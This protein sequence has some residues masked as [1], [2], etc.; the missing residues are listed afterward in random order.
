MRSPTPDSIRRCAMLLR[1]LLSRRALRS[2]VLGP[3]TLLLWLPASGGLQ[4]APK[5]S[6]PERSALAPRNTAPGVRYVGS[7]VCGSCHTEIFSNFRQTGMGRSMLPADDSSVAGLPAPVTVFDQD[8]SQYF[9]ILRKDGHWY[10]SQYALDG[11]GK[12][13]FRQTYKMDYVIGAGDNG[14]GFLIKRGSYLFEAPLSYYSQSHSWSFSPGYQFRNQAFTRPVVA[15]CIGCHSGRPNPVEGQIARYKDPPFDELAVGCE[16]CHGPGDLHVKERTQEQMM[17]AA[18]TDS[19]DP[20]IVNPARLSGWFSDNICMR[21]HQGQDVRVDQPGT[22]ER[23]FR[24]GM[25]LDRVI[26]IF[27]VPLGTQPPSG[28]ML[29]EHYFGMTLSKCYRATAGG[30]HCVSCHDPHQQMSG[31]V[32]F[33]YYRSRCLKCHQDQSCTLSRAKRLATTPP[34]DCVGCHM[35]KRTVTTITHAALTDHTIPANPGV[36]VKG[37]VVSGGTSSSELLHL[38]A[39][40]GDRLNL[41]SVPPVV[42]AQAYESL[43][44]N[45]HEEFKPKLDQA[46]EQVAHSKSSDPVALR[47]L[48]RQA[49]L[50]NTPEARQQAIKDM[51]RVIHDGFPNV[52]DYTLLADLYIRENRNPEAVVLL[53]KAR[54]ANPYFPEIY[55]LLA[56]QY[57]ALGDY[58][59][60]I[61]ILQKGLELFPADAK[62]RTLDKSARSATLD[63]IAQ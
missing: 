41:H 28:S 33:D 57:M 15:A 45:K 32:A 16:N 39:P 58:R 14:L 21:C 6:A 56:A 24:P 37:S 7:K 9:Q 46:L 35:P 25:T 54:V 5:K 29:L 27:K 12:E 19:P 2:A 23:D 51:S 36:T 53:E 3:V 38:S 59:H 47:I 44:R 18:L 22:S 63:G 61:A 1:R 34:D 4:T 42:L 43:V 49:S 10:Q 11:A 30:L 26:S 40:L 62:L 17:G 20:D 13:L 55:E 31:Q 48:A 8:L 60:A 50:Q 52:D